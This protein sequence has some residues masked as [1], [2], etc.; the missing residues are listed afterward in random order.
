MTW[1]VSGESFASAASAL[2]ELAVVDC[3]A[4][5]AKAKGGAD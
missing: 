2:M 1:L 4:H 5:Q 3:M